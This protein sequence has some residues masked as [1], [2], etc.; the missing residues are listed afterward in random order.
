ML[1]NNRFSQ[2]T[3]FRSVLFGL[4]IRP[5]QILLSKCLL[6]V[7]TLTRR[8]LSVRCHVPSSAAGRTSFSEFSHDWISLS[9][10]AD[11]LTAIAYIRLSTSFE[12]I[13]H[14]SSCERI[15]FSKS[16]ADSHESWILTTSTNCL[17]GVLFSSDMP[18]RQRVF[19]DQGEKEIRLNFEV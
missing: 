1:S 6:F 4:E 14:S 7:K 8:Y 18:V 9:N 3:A 2:L 11:R 12:V 5:V 16:L 13:L 19:G 10:C 17:V 15:I